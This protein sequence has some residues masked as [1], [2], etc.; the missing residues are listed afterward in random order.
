MKNIII[1]RHEIGQSEI[2][3]KNKEKYVHIFKFLM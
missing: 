1:I 3:L 2:G